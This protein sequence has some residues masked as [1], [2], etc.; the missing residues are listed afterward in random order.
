[1]NS[2]VNTAIMEAAVIGEANEE[3]GEIVKAVIVLREG[4]KAGE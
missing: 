2:S 1:M 3:W 4:Q